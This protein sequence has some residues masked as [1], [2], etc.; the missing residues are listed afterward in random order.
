MPNHKELLKIKKHLSD[1]QKALDTLSA[2]T[3]AFDKHNELLEVTAIQFEIA[4]LEIRKLCEKNKLPVRETIPPG[5]FLHGREI[6]GEAEITDNGWLHIRLNTLL[7]ST[8]LIANSRYVSESITQLL[9][10]FAAYGGTLPFFEKAFM[11]IIERC[12]FEGRRSFDNDNK[13]F[14][15]II[16]ALK[17][18][19]FPDDDQF[20]LSL[21][22][23][24]ELDNENACHVFV[25]NETEAGDFF[26]WRQE[27]RP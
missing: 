13:A 11:A 18:R 20:E 10:N 27:N 6:Y 5:T 17:G 9:N 26:D 16:N 3:F 21:G 8:K 14:A 19:L 15:S 2:N 24:T 12:D 25:M 23:F 22:L 4:V 1:A 7:P